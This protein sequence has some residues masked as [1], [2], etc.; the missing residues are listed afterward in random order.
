MGAAFQ[1]SLMACASQRL[2]MR[3]DLKARS[4]GGCT[5]VDFEDKVGGVF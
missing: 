1:I 4:A 3:D 5:M 2:M